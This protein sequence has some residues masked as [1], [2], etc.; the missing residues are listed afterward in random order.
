M[1]V[2]GAEPDD[3]MLA[4]LSGDGT[5]T[6]FDDDDGPFPDRESAARSW[7][8]ARG[9]V[10]ASAYR[11]EVWPPGAAA[12]YD[13]LRSRVEAAGHSVRVVA[14]LRDLAVE[15]LADV[16]RFRREKPKAAQQAGAGLD[17][18][19]TALRRLLESLEADKHVP[20]AEAWTALFDRRT[21]GA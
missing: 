9:V 11:E 4:F 12:A 7:E 2:A 10:W 15:D 14:E 17:D 1:A 20:S 16:V 19:E 5:D 3:V 21:R 18:Y 8:W 13:G 6:P